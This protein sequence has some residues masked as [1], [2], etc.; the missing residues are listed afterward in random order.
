MIHGNADDSARWYSL[1][2]HGFSYR[3]SDHFIIGE[4]ASRDGNDLLLVHPA[5]IEGLELLRN[6]LGSP[7]HINSAFRTKSHN[8]AIQIASDPKYVPGSSRSRH[9]YGLAADVVCRNV[10]PD[11]VA[12]IAN[13]M[14]FGGVGSYN[15]FTHID[16]SRAS[17][18]WDNRTNA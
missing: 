1:T 9:L 16:V 7:L 18:R 5:L 10:K 4:M 6:R 14:G 17:R 11:D 15:S 13:E 3:L 12:R 8:E 2:L